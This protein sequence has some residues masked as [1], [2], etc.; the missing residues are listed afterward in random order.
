MA[1]EDKMKERE[2]VLHWKDRKEEIVKGKDI[3]DAFTKAGYGAGAVSALD[4]FSYHIPNEYL[5]QYE[6]LKKWNQE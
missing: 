6:E 2:F 4:Y 1:K 3:A 5:K